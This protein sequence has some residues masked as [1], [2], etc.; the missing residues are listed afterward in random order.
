[1]TGPSVIG[2]RTEADASPDRS[3]SDRIDALDGL[4]GLAIAGVIAFHLGHLRG[5]YLGVDLFFVVSGFLISRQ[6]LDRRADGPSD[7][8]LRWFWGRRVR[9][10]LPSL[11]VCIAATTAWTIQVGTGPLVERTRAQALAGLG[12]VSNWWEIHAG[13]GYWGIATERTPLGH[14]WSLSVEEQVYIAWPLLV[15]LLLRAGGGRRA[16]QIVVVLGAAASF[17]AQCLLGGGDVQR[18]YLGT[19][20]RV[21]AVL[22]GSGVAIWAHARAARPVGGSPRLWSLIGTLALAALGVAWVTQGL[23]PELFRGRLAAIS[24][25]AALAV[26]AITAAPHG[27][28]ARA[29]SR[30]GL[31]GVGR[32]SYLL[33]LWHVPVIVLVTEE[34]TGFGAAQVL[35]L[36]AAI[37]LVAVAVTRRYIERPI[38]THGWSRGVR[39]PAV[40]AGIALVVAAAVLPP[41]L[42]AGEPAGAPSRLTAPPLERSF[43][44]AEV[45]DLSIMVVGDSWG[46]RT[47]DTMVTMS[48]PRPRSVIRGAMPSCG[49]ADPVLEVAGNGAWFAPTEECLAWRD[50]WA[51]AWRKVV[52]TSPSSRWAT[53]TRRRSGSSRTV[54]SSSRATRPTSSATASTSTRRSLS[55]PARTATSL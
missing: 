4:R 8:I 24:L 40:A 3:E 47:Q 29:L 22:L 45:E 38:H 19:D 23:E 10:L 25:T 28:L 53:G 14:L 50:S 26:V 13:R 15:L 51:A 32:L 27:A 1:M 33:Y 46:I 12:F 41:H 7:G 30:P 54:P 49:I 39:G 35:G 20:S 55:S 18:A 2:E 42:R 17:A 37:T 44:R 5:G 48:R 36:Q 43:T 21:G 9:R 52:R 31:M 16:L 11:I 6:L 34:R